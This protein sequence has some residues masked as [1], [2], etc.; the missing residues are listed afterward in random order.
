MRN[1][2]LIFDT[3]DE[4]KLITVPM[5]NSDFAKS[6]NLLI[7]IEQFD[8]SFKMLSVLLNELDDWIIDPNNGS[9]NQKR[10][11]G[12]YYFFLGSF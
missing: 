5:R 3:M 6:S 9:R 1:Q 8:W 4:I 12:R 11:D 2:H 10:A 7:E